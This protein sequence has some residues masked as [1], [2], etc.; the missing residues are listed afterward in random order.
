LKAGANVRQPRSYVTRRHEGW[1]FRTVRDDSHTARSVSNSYSSA[2]LEGSAYVSLDL[3]P[4]VGIK[5]SSFQRIN[6]FEGGIGIGNNLKASLTAKAEFENHVLK[7]GCILNCDITYS[8]TVFAYIKPSEKDLEKLWTKDIV[9]T[10]T[11]FEK[12]L[13]NYDGNSAT[14][15]DG[16]DFTPKECLKNGNNWLVYDPLKKIRTCAAYPPDHYLRPCKVLSYD[17][18]FATMKCPGRD[19]FRQEI[20]YCDPKTIKYQ[21]GELTCTEIPKGSYR[22]TCSD[23]SIEGSRLTATCSE[24]RSTIDFGSCAPDSIVNFNGQLRCTCSGNRAMMAESDGSL[25]CQ[26]F[27]YPRC[28]FQSC[29]VSRA[30]DLTTLNANCNGVSSNPFTLR[31]CDNLNALGLQ[32]TITSSSV[33][34]SCGVVA[35][36]RCGP[37]FGTC[38][39]VQC[40]SSSGHCG[41]TSQFCGTGCQSGFG[42]CNGSPPRPP[43]PTTNL[44]TTQPG[45]RCG[46]G[47]A[48][49]PS[50]YSC[51][52]AG[53]CGNT[54]CYQALGCQPTFGVCPRP[55]PTCPDLVLP[56]NFP[57][58]CLT[59]SQDVTIKGTV[60]TTS[61]RVGV[62]GQLSRTSID[63][64]VCPG[65][66]VT[67]GNLSGKLSCTF[68]PGS[69]WTNSATPV[70]GKCLL[71]TSVVNQNILTT[72]CQQAN[73]AWT[74]P[75]IDVSKC[76]ERVVQLNSN[77]TL[78]CQR[79]I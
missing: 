38:S 48:L 10:I 40:C 56:V 54:A 11:I 72:Q 20:R 8:P 47:W 60:L 78:S 50:G 77:G 25:T 52:L 29:V 62:T 30:A 65:G 64:S 9:P 69:W 5:I 17:G 71:A 44:P 57:A 79:P 70:A 46:D 68:P 16:S 39:G 22:R 74:V 31:N 2:S 55:Q 61:C 45:G 67:N 32:A 63:L 36:G 59:S 49:C 14:I 26:E 18:V 41:L 23:F 58:T 7:P 24:R 75:S 6:V 53:Y 33:T 12:C 19:T 1:N 15:G 51:S 34:I 28:P 43:P 21:N 66:Q 3:D 35:G 13:Y 76:R 37:G 42:T 73:L 27:W 4:R